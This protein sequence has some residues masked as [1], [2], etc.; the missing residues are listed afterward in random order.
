MT[1]IQKVYCFV[2]LAGLA[3]YSTEAQTNTVGHVELDDGGLARADLEYFA[4][5]VPEVGG[6][7]KVH[8]GHPVLGNGVAACAV[9][10]KGRGGVAAQREHHHKC[11]DDRE[12]IPGGLGKEKQRCATRR[13]L[14][15]IR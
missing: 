12:G 2:V 15:Q 7:L 11:R 5:A 8:N 4:Q 10:V 1:L 6:G 3:L 14:Q 9:D 13:R